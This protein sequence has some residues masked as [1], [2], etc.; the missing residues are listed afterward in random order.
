MDE[1]TARSILLGGGDT[2]TNVGAVPPGMTTQAG[3]TQFGIPRTGESFVERNYQGLPIDLSEGASAGT[4]VGAAWRDKPEQKIKYLEGIY[5]AGNVRSAHDGTLLIKVVGA[6]N[7]PKEVPLS[8]QGV[9]FADVMALAAYAPETLGALAAMRGARSLPFIGK[10]G[11][12]AE[13]IAPAKAVGFLRDIG[14]EAIG[15]EAGGALKDIAVTALDKQPVDM[16]GILAERASRLPADV[17]VGAGLGVAGKALGKAVTP[18]GDTKAAMEQDLLDATK[19]FKEQYGV[20][21]PLTAGERTGRNLLKRTE[22]MM[23]RLPG[24]S[25]EFADI[26]TEK[27]DRLRRIMNNMLGL[28]EDITAAERAALPSEEAVG[29]RAIA[30]I[31][32]EIDPTKAAIQTARSDTA[33]LANQRIMDNLEAAAGTAD[34][35]LYPEK[36]GQSIRTKAFEK[37]G[38]FQDQSRVLYEDAYSLPGGTEKVLE[39]KSLASEAKKLLEEFPSK[40][41]VTS[42]EMLIRGPRGEVITKTSEGKEVL[43]AFV[44][45]GVKAKVETLAGLEG[46][47]FSLQELVRMRTEVANDIAQGEAI[48]GMQTHYLNKVR[49]TLTAAIEEAADTLPDGNLKTAW[50]KANQFYKENVGQFHE[51][52]VARLFKDIESRGFVSDENIIRNISPT[53]Y[54]VFKKFLGESSPEFTKL[55]RAIVDELVQSSTL[56]GES[57]ID[58][59][60]FMRELTNLYNTKRSIADDI[61]GG[62]EPVGVIG[63]KARISQLSAVLQQVDEPID[64]KKFLDVLQSDQPIRR[65]VEKIVTEEKKLA[66]AYRSQIVKDIGERKLGESFDASEFVNRFYKQASPREMESVIA[67]LQGDPVVLE[68][69]RRKVV[70]RVFYDAQR[71]IKDTDPSKLGRGELFRP[72]GA[73]ELD[74]VLGDPANREKLQIALGN[75]TYNDLVEMGK[76]LRAGEVT[77]TAFASAGGLSSGMQTASMIRG[78]IFGYMEDWAKQKLAAILLTTPGFRQWAGNTAMSRASQVE[79]TRAFIASAPFV[80]AVDRE[81]DDPGSTEDFIR[82]VGKSV[83]AYEKYGPNTNVTGQVESREQKAERMK[84]VLSEPAVRP[85]P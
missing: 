61:I 17:A 43:S 28:P 66:D 70:E 4:V 46:Q 32:S 18:F 84:R 3:A 10:A 30:Q 62:T 14:A 76:L 82:A 52:P 36:V 85:V 8:A 16:G 69:L 31:R 21:F 50:K 83:G 74:R 15:Q 47:K 6:N 41:V 22:Q 23:S 60:A 54:A 79:L 7:A 67:Q 56:P 24:S 34:R 58:G 53:E 64:A 40:N 63:R 37:R 57:L 45:S 5:G 78:G 81:F 75:R 71:A 27:T 42:E 26:R 2:G 20:E 48:P 1:K 68:N 29:G 73:K 80:E 12:T 65:G 72:S 44:P 35:Q 11:A 49:D 39:S 59:K 33:K 38:Q 9:Q 55:K 13:S 51:G 19:Y 77:E 25:K